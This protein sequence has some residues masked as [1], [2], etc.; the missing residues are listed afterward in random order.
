MVDHTSFDVTGYHQLGL[1]IDAQLA[2]VAV[3]INVICPVWG[4]EP[5]WRPAREGAGSLVIT[6]IGIDNVV[7]N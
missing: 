4:K 2:R 3:V 1:R 6:A 5:R 7:V